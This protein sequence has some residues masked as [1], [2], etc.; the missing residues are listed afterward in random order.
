MRRKGFVSM[1]LHSHRRRKT[2]PFLPAEQIR[3]KIDNKF[4]LSLRFL[5]GLLWENMEH[6]VGKVVPRSLPLPG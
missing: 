6:A 5:V 4:G 1:R 2:P 3:K